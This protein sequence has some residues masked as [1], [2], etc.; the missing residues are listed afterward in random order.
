MC[1][2]DNQGEVLRSFK[3]AKLPHHLLLD[4]EGHMLVTDYYNHRVLLLNSQLRLQRVL[5]DRNSQ[6][7]VWA[8]FRLCYDELASQ[9]FVLHR[10]GELGLSKSVQSKVISVF[11]LLSAHSD[12][13]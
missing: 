10:I 4:S 6:V 9:L 1:E 7:K 5:V 12:A 11:S 8:P 3:E 2:I 13:E